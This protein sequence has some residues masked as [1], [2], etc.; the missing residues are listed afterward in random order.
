MLQFSSQWSVPPASIWRIIFLKATVLKAWWYQLL[1]PANLH[2]NERRYSPF[3]KWSNSQSQNANALMVLERKTNRSGSNLTDKNASKS[4]EYRIKRKEH[5]LFFRHEAKRHLVTHWT[6]LKCFFLMKILLLPVAIVLLSMLATFWHKIQC[7]LSGAET[8]LNTCVCKDTK[9]LVMIQ[10]W[11]GS[12]SESLPWNQLFIPSLPYAPHIPGYSVLFS[13]G[14][15]FFKAG[16]FP[17]AA[18]SKAAG[19]VSPPAVSDRQ[20]RGS[21]TPSGSIATKC[22]VSW[23]NS[24]S[25]YTFVSTSLN[26]TN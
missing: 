12:A 16:A 22:S 13:V 7:V 3:I 21:G 6:R 20:E 1:P 19:V 23:N 15:G 24:P 2:R 17:Q 11:G 10:A 5:W 25:N 8:L 18:C 14:L 4:C 9:C 26:F